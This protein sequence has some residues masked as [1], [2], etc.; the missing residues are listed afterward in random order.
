MSERTYL[1]FDGRLYEDQTFEHIPGWET[2]TRIDRDGDGDGDGEKGPYRVE[3]RSADGETLVSRA[4]GVEFDIACSPGGFD[5]VSSGRVTAYLPRHPNTRRLTFRRGDR[6]IFERPV[7]T[8]RPTIELTAVEGGSKT[9]DLS[10][11]ASARGDADLTYNVGAVVDGVVVPLA[12]GLEGVDFSIPVDD[13]PVSTAAFVVVATDGLRSRSVVSEP[14]DI[15]GERP[16]ASVWI[17]SPPD[18]GEYPAD[19]P[20]GLVGNALNPLSGALPAENLRWLVDGD[21]VAAGMRTAFAAD[22][23]PGEHEVTLEYRDGDEADETAVSESVTVTVLEPS[24]A[25]LEHRRLM[26][27]LD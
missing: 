22:L 8:Q 24:E 12:A 17:Q 21:D 7:A 13:V 14:I 2:A 23:D 5:G 18:G 10:W 19:Q 25:Q 9:V 1:R 26:A 27:E 20:V 16:S 6:V 4:V 3:L 15:H 11:S